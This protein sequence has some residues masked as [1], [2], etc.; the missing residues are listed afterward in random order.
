MARFPF[1]A[2]FDGAVVSGS[3]GIVKPEPAIYLRLIKRYSNVPARA[4]DAGLNSRR[5][6]DPVICTMRLSGSPK[7]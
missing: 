7:S 5:A 2:D 4:G 3:E 1:L 6:A